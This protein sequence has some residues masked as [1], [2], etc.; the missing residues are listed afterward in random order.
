MFLKELLAAGV[1]AISTLPAFGQE[2]DTN[3]IFE[4]NPV[5]VA[6]LSQQEMKETKGAWLLMPLAGGVFSGAGYYYNNPNWNY[7][8]LTTAVTTGMLGGAIGGFAGS[9][10]ATLGSMYSTHVTSW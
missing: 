3:L 1:L 8:G 6:A 7:A 5:E 10:I 4:D 2:L 9:G